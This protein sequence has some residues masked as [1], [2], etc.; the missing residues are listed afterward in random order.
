[1]NIVVIL[2]LLLLHFQ[3]EALGYYK[4]SPGQLIF[5]ISQNPSNWSYPTVVESR[6]KSLNHVTIGTKIEWFVAMRCHQQIK[7]TQMNTQNTNL[8][9]TP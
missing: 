6:Y 2:L 8:K 4:S 9:N 3:T 5:P 7:E 1:M